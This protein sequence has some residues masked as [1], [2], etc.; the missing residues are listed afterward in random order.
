MRLLQRGSLDLEGLHSQAAQ[1]C[2]AIRQTIRQALT[3]NLRKEM[4]RH[5]EITT[6]SVPA[7]QNH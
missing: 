6:D 4:A 3:Y 5:T 2:P 1:R 7:I